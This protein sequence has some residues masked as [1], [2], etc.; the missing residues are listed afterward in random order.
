M[1]SKRQ[2]KKIIKNSALNDLL[3]IQKRDCFSFDLLKEGKISFEIESNNKAHVFDSIS[4][5]LDGIA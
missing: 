4:L 2:F 5:D 1:K 3:M